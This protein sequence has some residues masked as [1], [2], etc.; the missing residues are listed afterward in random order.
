[1]QKRL[2]KPTLEWE[3]PIQVFREEMVDTQSILA[4]VG[5]LRENADVEARLQRISQFENP[6]TV[7]EGLV[8]SLQY[9][10]VDISQQKVIGMIQLRCELNDYLKHFGGH[11]GYSIAPSERRKG[12][13]KA[14]LQACLTK[15]KEE[16]LS[17]VL[18]TCDPSNEGSRGVILGCGGRYQE[19]VYHPEEARYYEHY[20]LEC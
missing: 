19:T 9:I 7:P 16:G 17:E 10:Y 2:I 5:S 12:N 6:A 3:K 13:G 1:M 20:W 8:R 4:G 11:I 18:I 15:A 14:M